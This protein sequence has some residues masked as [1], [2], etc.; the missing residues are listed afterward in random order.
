MHS[1]KYSMTRFTPTYNILVLYVND[2]QFTVYFERR[3][4]FIS[5][6]SAEWL[7][8]LLLQNVS[9]KDKLL[10]LLEDK[11]PYPTTDFVYRKGG[12]VL[13]S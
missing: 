6:R 5:L 10:L 11:T 4:K 12:F 13:T 8:L 7:R 3:K 9:S 1:M 2:I